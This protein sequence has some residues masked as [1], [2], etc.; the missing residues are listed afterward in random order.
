MAYLDGKLAE[1]GGLKP[2][3]R[4]VIDKRIFSPLFVEEFSKELSQFSGVEVEADF[5]KYTYGG[6][7]VP[8]KATHPHHQKMT[9]K[10]LKKHL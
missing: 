5:K 10:E 3:M 1:K 2:F 6:K 8:E 9:L 7:S 4:H